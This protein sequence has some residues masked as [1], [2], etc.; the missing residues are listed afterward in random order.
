MTQLLD[1]V[2]F[3]Y[4]QLFAP[5][6]WMVSNAEGSLII[7]DCSF[8]LINS[9]FAHLFL[10]PLIYPARGSDCGAVRHRDNPQEL[11]TGRDVQ[12]RHPTLLRID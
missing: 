6:F 8:V 3:P 2:Y 5:R 4:R 12:N 10:V 11:G 9:E 7:L 1:G